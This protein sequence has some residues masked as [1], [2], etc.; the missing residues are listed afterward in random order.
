M[1]AALRSIGLV[2]LLACLMVATRAQEPDEPVRG[3][4]LGAAAL[5]GGT[6]VDVARGRLVPNS[7]V[8]IRGGRI[9]RVGTEGAVSVPPG[10]ARISTAGMTVLPGLWDMHT[11]LQYSAH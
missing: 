10:Y 1:F 8:F 5:V 4:D 9:E 6:L 7:V 3:A 2:L 11:H